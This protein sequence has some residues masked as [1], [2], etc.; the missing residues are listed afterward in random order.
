M[1]PWPPSGLSAWWGRRKAI[2]K[3]RFD[4]EMARL[5]AE[6]HLAHH[7]ARADIE[8]D[9][10]WA[11]EDQRHTLRDEILIVLW[12]LPA[13]L[14]FV[15]HTRPSAIEALEALKAFA[16]EAPTAYVAGWAVILTAVFGV[17]QL[18]GLFLPA[19]FASLAQTLGSLPPD[20][21]TI[22]SPSSGDTDGDAHANIDKD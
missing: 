20:V 2:R 9:M 12:A 14:L 16:P 15:P 17:K 18:V 13:L 4:V 8:W 19:K 1:V 5:R 6:A 10:K 21:P 3:A 11:H 22:G 7:K